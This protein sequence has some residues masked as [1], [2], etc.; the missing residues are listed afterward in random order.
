MQFNRVMDDED[1]IR[2]DGCN[3]FS[4]IKGESCALRRTAWGI[5]TFGR[6]AQRASDGATAAHCYRGTSKGAFCLFHAHNVFD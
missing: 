4:R 6:A 5:W 3:Y 2:Q 1:K